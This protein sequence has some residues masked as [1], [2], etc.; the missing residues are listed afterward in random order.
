MYF[1]FAKN[2]SVSTMKKWLFLDTIQVKLG[3]WG[4]SVELEKK[5]L[6]FVLALAFTADTEC[7]ASAVVQQQPVLLACVVSWP[8]AMLWNKTKPPDH[9]VVLQKLILFQ[10]PL[11]LREILGFIDLAAWLRQSYHI[12]ARSGLSVK[13]LTQ[14]AHLIPKDATH[15]GCPWHL[16]ALKFLPGHLNESKEWRIWR[17][18]W[19][20]LL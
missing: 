13:P 3:L 5:V 20:E 11:L 10:I 18:I 4:D 15:K 7:L 1:F 9:Q 6:S 19:W 2:K 17:R 8:R 16:R 12:T 14:V